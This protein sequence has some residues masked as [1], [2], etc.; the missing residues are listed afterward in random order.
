[1][2]DDTHLTEEEVSFFNQCLVYV[3]FKLKEYQNARILAGDN[4]KKLSRQA[5]FS[6]GEQE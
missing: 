6:F 4:I 3:F 2:S 1:M 5:M